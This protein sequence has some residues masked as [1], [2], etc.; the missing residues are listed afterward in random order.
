LTQDLS[1]VFEHTH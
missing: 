1:F